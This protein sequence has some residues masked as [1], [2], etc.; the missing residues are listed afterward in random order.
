MRTIDWTFAILP[1]ANRLSSDVV[2][3]C[4]S[5]LGER[6]RANFLAYEVSSARLAVQGLG[7]G[8]S[9]RWSLM[10]SVRKTC[11]ALKRGQLRMG[12]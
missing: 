4:Q 6:G 10:S 7:H 1:F 5:C 3:P 9:C 11:L 8:F 2:K 12:T